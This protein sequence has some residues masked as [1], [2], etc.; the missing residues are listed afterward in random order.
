MN[1]GSQ[2]DIEWPAVN[3]GCRTPC[4]LELP[5]AAPRNGAEGGG[6]GRREGGREGRR[7]GAEEGRKVRTMIFKEGSHLCFSLGFSIY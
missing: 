5:E 6:G 1:Q 3:L 4:N 7:K 2:G